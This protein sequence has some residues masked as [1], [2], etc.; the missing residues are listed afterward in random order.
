MRDHHSNRG[1][2]DRLTGDL[3]RSL[4]LSASLSLSLSVCLMED[5]THPS[6]LPSTWSSLISLLVPN[7]LEADTMNNPLKAFISRVRHPPQHT[8]ARTRAHT[9]TPDRTLSVFLLLRL[10]SFAAVA[11]RQAAG[12]D[13]ETPQQKQPE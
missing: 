9:T 5:P 10:E 3:S 1:A 2:I 4:S 7:G 6:G 12:G 13:T 11:V 8:H